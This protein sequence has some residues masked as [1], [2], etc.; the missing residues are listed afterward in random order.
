MLPAATLADRR[1]HHPKTHAPRQTGKTTTL[2][3]MTGAFNSDGR[4]GCVYANI[5]RAQALRGNVTKAIPSVCTVIARAIDIHTP[6][7]DM[8][9]WMRTEGRRELP[10]DQLSY[11]LDHWAQVAN[12]PTVL[13]LDEVD[14]LVGDSLMSLLRQVRSGYEERPAYFPQ[15]I[16]LCGVRDLRDYRMHQGD[17]EVI[18]GA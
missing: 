11:L 2:R 10:Q 5:E 3:A 7:L 6:G 17:G 8:A 14:A 18:W 1:R 15:S 4:Y 16:M 9:E 12:K 13:L